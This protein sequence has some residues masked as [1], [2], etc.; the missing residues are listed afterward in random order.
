MRW[1]QVPPVKL[2][3]SRPINIP[4]S[5]LAEINYAYHFDASLYAR[6][7][8]GYAQQRGVVHVEGMIEHIPLDPDTGFIK[9][10]VLKSGEVI[11]G[12]F[13]YRL[14]GFSF[15][16]AGPNSGCWL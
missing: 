10:L 8:S 4:G 5:P 9:S 13:I 2:R 1:R 11:E 12:G 6:Y 15:I 7:L 16:V 14:L 3:F